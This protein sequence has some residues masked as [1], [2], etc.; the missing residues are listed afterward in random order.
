LVAGL[1]G[2]L[3]GGLFGRVGCCLCGGGACGGACPGACGAGAADGVG[4]G[5]K[6]GVG[7]AGTGTGSGTGSGQGVGEGGGGGGRWWGLWSLVGAW[8]AWGGPGG[9]R[10]D[11]VPV[12]SAYA[13]TTSKKPRHATKSKLHA[14]SGC[15]TC[16]RV[17]RAN[18][19][20][21]SPES[22]DENW[23][24]N[25]RLGQFRISAPVTRSNPNPD[26]YSRCGPAASQASL[27]AMTAHLKGSVLRDRK[28]TQTG[29]LALNNLK[30]R[31]RT[32]NTS[33]SLKPVQTK[34][35]AVVLLP[36]IRLDRRHVRLE[37][38]AL[39]YVLSGRHGRYGLRMRCRCA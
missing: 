36:D 25:H 35:A 39:R 3:L 32:I 5:V 34:C 16:T 6:S 19:N 4:S 2:G 10:G 21:H 17:T 33:P 12:G 15:F 31:R 7:G 22:K 26:S 11:G 18:P 28:G 9:R 38:L 30:D 23:V 24:S 1:L 37:R 13:K 27:R 29:D 8:G 14:D 20:R